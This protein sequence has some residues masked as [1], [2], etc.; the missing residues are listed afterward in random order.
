MAGHSPSRLRHRLFLSFLAFAAAPSLVLVVLANRGLEASLE[1]W[2]TPAVSRALEGSLGVARQA[3][4][5]SRP[6]LEDDLD[7]LLAVLP[8][9]RG[10][11]RGTARGEIVVP[12]GALTGTAFDALG[13]ASLGRPDRIRWT[14]RPGL[15]PPRGLVE[16]RLA[17]LPGDTLVVAGPDHLALLHVAAGRRWAALTPLSPGIRAALATVLEAQAFYDEL[18]DYRRVARRGLLAGTL[19]IGL[20]VIVISWI[21]ASAVARGVTGPLEALARAMGALS[22]GEPVAPVAGGG[23]EVRQLAQ[24]FEAM[25]RDLEASRHELARAERAAAWREVARRIA[26]EIKN[27]LTPVKLAVHRLRSLEAALEPQDRTRL[28]ESLDAVDREVESLRRMADAFSRFSRLPEPDRRPVTVPAVVRSVAEMYEGSPLR[29]EWSAPDELTAR[30]DEGQLRQAL[31]NLIQ[32]G[33]D[34]TGGGGPVRVEV[35]AAARAGRAGLRIRVEDGGPGF[36]AEAL[37]RAGEPYFTEK[38]HGTGLGLAMVRQIVEGHGGAM[39]LGN[40]PGGG[41]RVD[42]WIPGEEGA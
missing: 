21:G 35:S 12:P 24:A 19:G 41:A 15:S 25:A 29:L 8:R 3:L 36:G 20:L 38:T 39:E 34:A 28:A 42:L 22:R 23:A 14:T 40:A 9:A 4:A 26:H 32:N 37:A 31:H 1:L 2:R 5:V 11:A 17:A 6:A 18:D 27:P 7:S 16:R 13:M 30:L 33:S 10:T